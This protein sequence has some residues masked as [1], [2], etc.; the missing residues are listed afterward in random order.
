MITKEEIEGARARIQSHVI[1]TPLLGSRRLGDMAGVR[2]LLKCES[3]QRTGSF[4]AR[5]AL[6][7]MMQLTPAEKKR[8]VVTVSAGN[9]AQALA[10]AASLV[11]AQCL[12]VMPEGATQSKV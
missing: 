3:F 8:G 7:A 2:L 10:W 5:G 6:N 9:H 1:E 11:G 4:K 12:A